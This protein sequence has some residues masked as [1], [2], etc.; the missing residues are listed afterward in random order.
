MTLASFKRFF[1][2]NKVNVAPRQVAPTPGMTAE[3]NIE[4]LN[5]ICALRVLTACMP[6]T[7]PEVPLH[8]TPGTGTLF[9]LA[10][11]AGSVPAIRITWSG[12]CMT[13]STGPVRSPQLP[14]IMEDVLSSFSLTGEDYIAGM[15]I[16]R[17]IVR[18][19]RIANKAACD[20]SRENRKNS[21]DKLVFDEYLAAF[22]NH[23]DKLANS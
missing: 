2:K 7:H 15:T 10:G 20:T 8:I 16:I 17:P 12:M 18:R 11:S 6:E 3:Q 9:L 5:Q 13:V 1:T 23:S 21:G 19:W 14:L 22:R 4:W